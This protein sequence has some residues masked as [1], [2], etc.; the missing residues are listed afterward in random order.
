GK[1]LARK[2]D[3][4]LCGIS[5]MAGI[6]Q[7]LVFQLNR[8]FWECPLCL[9]KAETAD[10]A[11]EE[12]RERLRQIAEERKYYGRPGSLSAHDHEK[13]IAGTR[14]LR[15]G[16]GSKSGRRRKQVKKW[17]RYSGGVGE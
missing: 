13:T 8:G 12:I 2:R 7:A 14:R 17:R 10:E 1:H 4:P 15:P 6:E 5:L 16:S 9:S 11:E 3:E